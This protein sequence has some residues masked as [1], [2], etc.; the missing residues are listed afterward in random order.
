MAEESYEHMHAPIHVVDAPKIDENEDSEVDEFIDKYITCALPDKTK[1][2][3]ISNL[4]KKVKTY[5]HTTTCTKKNGL[6]LMLLGHH[7][8]K[9]E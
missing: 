2:P 3:E 9:P 1:Y 8:I 7:Q 6:D 5:H 4:V